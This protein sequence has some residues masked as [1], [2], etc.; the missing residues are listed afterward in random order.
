MLLRFIILT[1]VL[2]AVGVYAPVR[3]TAMESAPAASSFSAALLE[4]KH[5]VDPPRPRPTPGPRDNAF[6]ADFN[7]QKKAETPP[8]PRPKPGPKDG[9]EDE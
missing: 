1:G 4:Q 5:E 7:Q 8:R 3:A 6:A 9:G 2:V